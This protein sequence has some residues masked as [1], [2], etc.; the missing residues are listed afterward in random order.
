MAFSTEYC[1][2]AGEFARICGTTRDTL[3][4][5]HQQGILVPRRNEK[6]G[7]HYYSYAQ[8][9]SFYFIAA[10]R[11]VGCAAADIRAYLMGG[12]QAQFDQFVGKQYQNLLDQRAELD[13]QI[14]RLSVSLQLLEEIRAADTGGPVLRGLPGALTLLATPVQAKEAGS[15]ARIGAD[16]RRH[17]AVCQAAGVPCFPMG[18]AMEAADFLAGRYY[19]SQVF[20]LAHS[21]RDTP[22]PSS[23][24]AAIVCRDSDGDITVQYRRLADFIRQQGLE[25]VSPVYSLS[26]VNAIDP[27]ANRRYLKYVFVCTADEP[28]AGPAAAGDKTP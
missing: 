19:Y 15:F 23:R 4:Y 22:W 24:G 7:Y 21:G 16:V 8:V 3:R 12:E 18:A 20:S 13:A 6:N 11:S 9:A 27:N 1:I 17:M 26:L 28:V 2:P 25:P 10:F 5:Y 14:D